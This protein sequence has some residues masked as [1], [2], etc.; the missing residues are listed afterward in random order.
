MSEQ[1]M[2]QEIVRLKRELE[3]ANKSRERWREMLCAFIPIDKTEITPEE[4]ERMKKTAKPVDELLREI[5]P[6]EMH[7]AI[8]ED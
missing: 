6:P 3:A 2:A 4:F 5:L 1:D 7:A 8:H